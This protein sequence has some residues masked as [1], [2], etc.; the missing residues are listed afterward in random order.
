MRKY[1]ESFSGLNPKIFPR[2]VKGNTTVIIV[3][4]NVANNKYFP[5]L[6]RKNGFRLRMTNTMI[7]AEMT[8]SKN[9]P[10]LNWPS[11]A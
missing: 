7:D 2:G 4:V 1:V 8:D 6:L 11:F 10:V 5:G 9:H 3:M